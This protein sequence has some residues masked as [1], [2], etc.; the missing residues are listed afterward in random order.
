MKKSI[1][2]IITLLICLNAN[3]QNINKCM[4]T[5]LVS[6]EIRSNESYAE[7]R[8]FE[9]VRKITNIWKNK[10]KE[11]STITIPVVVHVVHKNTH[12]NPGT[13]SNISVAQIEDQIRILNEDFSKTNPEFPSPPRAT[14]NS[15]AGNADIKF[16]LAATD[17]NGNTTNGITRTSTTKSSFDYATESNDMKLNSTGGKDGW[18]PS[19]Y[20]NIW[21]CNL[22]GGGVLGYA[23]LPGLLA[24]GSN[25]QWKD[26]LVV[27][28]QYFGTTT[29]TTGDG[30]TATHEIGHYLGLNHTFS[31]QSSGW[32][33][34][35]CTDS[36]GNIQCCD[37]DI[38]NVD[39]TPA[40]LYISSW[41]TDGPYFGPVT[42]S[43]NNNTCNDINFQNAFNTNVI[44]MDENYM[45][46]AAN[47]WMFTNGQVN[48][49]HDVLNRSE[50]NYG[51]SGLKNS[52]VPTNCTGIISGSINTEIEKINIYPNPTKDIIY[53]KSNSKIKL[54]CITNI[55]GKEIFNINNVNEYIDLTA[56]GDGIYI[57]NIHTDSG[58]Y[59]E[60]IILAR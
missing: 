28:F 1:S 44:D 19:R 33:S 50:L 13:A 43:T 32:G 57:I 47:T 40:A 45:S 23:Y 8:N 52:T 39:D 29:G 21:V 49:M 3:T 25:Q 5:Q 31:E 38:A 10:K 53:V 2:L 11:L 60:R 9:H 7:A 15:I 59:S 12:A 46:Y 14:F 26:G 30:R 27:D 18:D 56:L 48:T 20:L 4:T 41:G 22:S 17:P 54:V 58:V 6:E 42:G 34:D 37:N 36:Q 51:R 35:P 16:C 24:F 55:V